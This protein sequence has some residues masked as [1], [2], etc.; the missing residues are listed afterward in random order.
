MPPVL[1]KPGV[2]FPRASP[3]QRISTVER[4]EEVARRRAYRFAS[5]AV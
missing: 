3:T 2:N 1:S 5:A 4:G